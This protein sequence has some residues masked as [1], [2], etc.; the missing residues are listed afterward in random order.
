MRKEA[1]A[2][3]CLCRPCENRA[4]AIFFE[5]ADLLLSF[6]SWCTQESKK[7]TV[8]RK[9]SFFS[10][11]ADEFLCLSCRLY[12]QKVRWIFSVEINFSPFYFNT[13][14]FCFVSISDFEGKSEKPLESA[15]FFFDRGI[16]SQG[17]EKL[18][19]V[20]RNPGKEKGEIYPV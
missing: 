15:L 16:F 17:N 14:K 9:H 19:K 3:L 10:K 11:Q 2:V 8:K 18:A 7:V 6:V 1:A 12:V 4:N 20:S 13:R 5:L